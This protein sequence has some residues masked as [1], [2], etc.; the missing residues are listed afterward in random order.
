MGT[1]KQLGYQGVIKLNEYLKGRLEKD[2]EMPPIRTDLYD[3]CRKH[4]GS[5]A[6]SNI[7]IE[8]IRR[9]V[10]NPVRRADYG[11]SRDGG[12][13]TK[14]SLFL[15]AHL[16]HLHMITGSRPPQSLVNF[17]EGKPTQGWEDELREL[18]DEQ[19]RV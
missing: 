18:A 6:Y 8:K 4:L 17:V 12:Y 1:R 13:G 10:G 2:R 11:G 5:E 16:L 14:A 15:A 3:D 7:S 19:L 9:V